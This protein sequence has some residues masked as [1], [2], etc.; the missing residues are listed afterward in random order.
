MEVDKIYNKYYNYP[1][2]QVE[3]ILTL[4]II[5]VILSLFIRWITF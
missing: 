5:L 1:R 2:T 4:L 3:A